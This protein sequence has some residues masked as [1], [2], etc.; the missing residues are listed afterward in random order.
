MLVDVGTSE[1]LV[2]GV[3]EKSQIFLRRFSLLAGLDASHNLDRSF[4]PEPL[5]LACEPTQS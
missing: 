5:A 1:E 3:I 4:D 2:T